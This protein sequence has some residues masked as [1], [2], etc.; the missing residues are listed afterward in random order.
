MNFKACNRLNLRQKAR[1]LVQGSVNKAGLQKFRSQHHLG[2]GHDGN[3]LAFLG[4]QPC[5]PNLRAP[6][7]MHRRRNRDNRGSL[8]G[9]ADEIAR[10][11]G[12][13][14]DAL[15]VFRRN[16]TALEVGD[17]RVRSNLAALRHE[18][19][20]YRAVART[21]ERDGRHVAEPEN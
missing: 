13:L 20:L 21:A 3:E 18:L 19:A 7:A 2:L 1:E 15:E 12:G 4:L 8:P 5:L 17:I 14:D 6:A 10:A 9:A 16:E 11:L